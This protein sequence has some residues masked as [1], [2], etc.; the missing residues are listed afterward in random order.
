M[1]IDKKQ[2]TCRVLFVG[3]STIVHVRNG[4]IINQLPS[5][6]HE[7]TSNPGGQVSV[8][9]TRYRL[10]VDEVVVDTWALEKNDQIYI[11]SDGIGKEISGD[12][13]R[14][15]PTH[16]A[17]ISN[18][19]RFETIVDLAREAKKVPNDDATLLRINFS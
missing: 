10:V 6:T 9:S 12:S 4:V 2:R 15:F 16:F 17:E 11:A 8:N 13:L 7:Y 3:D 1:K 14:N 5:P 19:R 18:Q